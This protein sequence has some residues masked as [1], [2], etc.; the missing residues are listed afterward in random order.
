MGF[1]ATVVLTGALVG[2]GTYELMNGM[3]DA[4]ELPASQPNPDPTK[5]KEQGQATVNN[6]RRALLAAGGQTDYTGGTGSLNN[7]DVAR[8]TLLVGG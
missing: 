3:N 8:T 4:P 2:A 7:S 5:A 1:L 6:Q